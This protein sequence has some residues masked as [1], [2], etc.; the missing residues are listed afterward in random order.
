MGGRGREAGEAKGSAK[1]KCSGG[2]GAA[3]FL[4]GVLSPGPSDPSLPA[5]PL[6]T[7]EPVKPSDSAKYKCL[8]VKY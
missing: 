2:E 8:V 4:L 3:V 5:G 6:P 1:R 7:K